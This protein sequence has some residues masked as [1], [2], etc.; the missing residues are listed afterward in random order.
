V[1]A[2]ARTDSSLLRRYQAL[3]Q[4]RKGSQALTRG[5]LT[6]LTPPSHGAP[7]LAFL[8][9]WGE[10]QVLVLHNL[11]D[12]RVTAGPFNAPG[13]MAEPLFTDSQVGTLSGSSGAWSVPLPAR[14][15]GIWRLR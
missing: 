11:T 15:T 12:S 14:A 6:L 5:G 9:S 1:Q 4:A 3:V 10:E 7:V 8:R 2:Q 13:T